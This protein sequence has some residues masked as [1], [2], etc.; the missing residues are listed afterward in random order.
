MKCELVLNRE[1]VIADGYS[2]EEIDQ[3]VA[4][5]EAEN[6]AGRF[7]NTATPVVTPSGAIRLVCATVAKGIESLTGA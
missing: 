2:D 6:K 7:D 3:V 4:F 5:C 1:A